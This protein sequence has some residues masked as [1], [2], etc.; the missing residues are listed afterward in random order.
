MK[1][2]NKKTAIN[3][4]ISIVLLSVTVLG[5]GKLPYEKGRVIAT[6]NKEALYVAD[7]KRDIALRM[8]SDPLFRITPKTLDTI[9]DT[10]INRKLLIQEAK[11][12]NLDQTDRFV[13]TIKIF[14]EQ[15]L[16]RDLMLHKDKEVEEQVSVSEKEM[17]DFYASLAERGEIPV[18]PYDEMKQ[19][20][21][22]MVKSNKKRELFNTWLTQIRENN[23]IKVNHNALKEIEYKNEYQ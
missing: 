21:R 15:T 10:L 22:E 18:Q 14:W 12:K 23:E 16:I 3:F 11:K 13:N 8:K 5:C 19:K 4:F 6:I 9:L 1:S 2:L 20:I 17:R 7:L